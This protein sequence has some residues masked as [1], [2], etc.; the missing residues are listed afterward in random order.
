[1]LLYN[2]Y[3]PRTL[4]DLVGQSVNT[5]ILK[6]LIDNNNIRP[7]YIF[8]GYRGTGKTTVGR[9][10]AKMLN[11]EKGVSS[12][13]CL[14]CD[15]CKSIEDGTAVEVRE[16]D[17]ASHNGVDYIRG[18]NEELNFASLGMR[19]KMWIL[20]EA[21]M[22]TK[23][24]WNALLKNLE[25]PPPGVI[26]VICTTE[27]NQIPDTIKSRC[28][29]FNFKKLSSEEIYSFLSH[30]CDKE[31]VT[32]EENALK[33]IS[34][35]AKGGMRDA[36]TEL[37]KAIIV[38]D[39][40]TLTENIASQITMSFNYKVVY[41]L[42]KAILDGTMSSALLITQGLDKSGITPSAIL[43]ELIEFL[44]SIYSYQ[45][46]KNDSVLLFASVEQKT[47]IMQLANEFDNDRLAE[48]IAD[49]SGAYKT[50]PYNP[51]PRYFLDVSIHHASKIYKEKAPF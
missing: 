7:C 12:T 44:H 43:D 39:G 16:I 5:K 40:K 13:P 28:L 49:L 14:E 19:Y 32:Y 6:N 51:N 26:F 33:I 4:A 29:R 37:E 48:V 20:D 25:E 31:G 50:L 24:A 36:L 11:C 8:S 41:F 10:L 46:V 42:A 30:V 18:I 38:A 35:N 1:M 3:R 47:D 9:I 15:N 22:M 2:K 27:I 23:Q 45:I 21:H 17:A 34:K